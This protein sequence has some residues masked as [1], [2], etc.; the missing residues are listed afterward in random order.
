MFI[1]VV[2]RLAGE[3]IP[4]T[5]FTVAVLASLVVARYVALPYWHSLHSFS[6]G[7]AYYRELSSDKNRYQAVKAGLM[8]KR[9][10]L[11]EKYRHVAP[12]QP[13]GASADLSGLLQLLIQRAADNSIRLDKIQPVEDRQRSEKGEYGVVLETTTSYQSLGRFLASIEGIPRLVSVE[14]LAVT[15]GRNGLETRILVTCHPGK[16][17]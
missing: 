14:R 15:A 10:L 5:G 11:A 2:R 4:F 3:I 9:N 1:T 7:A 6:E 13:Q 12:P 8:E 16:G 17:E